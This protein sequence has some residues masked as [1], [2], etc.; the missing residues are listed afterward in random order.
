MIL[1][2]VGCL[3]AAEQKKGRR[4]RGKKCHNKTMRGKKIKLWGGS[5]SFF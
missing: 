1:G 2:A 4:P 5:V 3:F